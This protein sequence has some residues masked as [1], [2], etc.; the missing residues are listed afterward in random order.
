MEA[1]GLKSPVELATF[2]PELSSSRVAH[3]ENEYRRIGDST[4][5]AGT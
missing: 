2:N 4:I 1:S 3:G 5:S